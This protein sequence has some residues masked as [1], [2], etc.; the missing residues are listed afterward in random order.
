MKKNYLTPEFMLVAL[1][2]KD[3]VCSSDPDFPTAGFGG[4]TTG[5]VTLK[6]KQRENIWDE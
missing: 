4:T 1:N 5:D 3:I 6:S 2:S